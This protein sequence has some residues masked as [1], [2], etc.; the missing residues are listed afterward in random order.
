MGN[1]IA[2]LRQRRIDRGPDTA[3]EGFPEHKGDFLPDAEVTPQVGHHL[4][5][6]LHIAFAQ[7]LRTVT[8]ALVP[9]DS[10]QGSVL[11][12]SLASPYGFG[13]ELRHLGAVFLRIIPL[14]LVEGIAGGLFDP[15]VQHRP[16]AGVD[17]QQ[18]RPAGLP[19]HFPGKGDAEIVTL[20]LGPFADGRIDVGV[21][22]SRDR[23]VFG[24]Q[25][26]HPFHGIGIFRLQDA[27][28][29]HIGLADAQIDIVVLG[30]DADAKQ[31]RRQQKQTLFHC[32]IRLVRSLKDGST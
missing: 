20:H 31:Q 27:A 10:L 11:H 8:F 22:R 7:F 28:A 30:K 6:T 16:A 29:G 19:V 4:A 15:L 18:H 12:R 5:Q 2:H 24:A 25:Q 23:R 17:D 21:P 9:Q 1:E 26:E 3:M 32:W 14:F 13:I